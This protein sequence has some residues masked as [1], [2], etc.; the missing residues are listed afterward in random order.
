VDSGVRVILDSPSARKPKV[1]RKRKVPVAAAG[2]SA[3]GGGGGGGGSGVMP[4]AIGVSSH[5]AFRLMTLQMS[6]HTI[7]SCCCL[8]HVIL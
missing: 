2:A 7:L 1:S 3:A 6:M 8:Y 5:Q 4:A